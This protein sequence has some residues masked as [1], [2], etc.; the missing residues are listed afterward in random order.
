[1]PEVGIC[2][3]AIMGELKSNRGKAWGDMYDMTFPKG[4]M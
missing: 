3:R 2:N 4:V 1:M